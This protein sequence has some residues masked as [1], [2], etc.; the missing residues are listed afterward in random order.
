LPTTNELL[1]T[2][3]KLRPGSVLDGKGRSVNYTDL[4]LMTAKSI[5]S[6][7]NLN[8]NHVT[9][10]SKLYL[11]DGC[12]GAGRMPKLKSAKSVNDAEHIF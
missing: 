1:E 5:L 6:V 4:V 7:I 10:N 12:D 3:K 2:R 8:E 11:T 9:E